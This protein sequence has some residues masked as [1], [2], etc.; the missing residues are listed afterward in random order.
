MTSLEEE[1]E[2]AY[3][4]QFSRY[5][6]NGIKADMVEDMYTKAHAA[7]RANPDHKAAAEKQVTKTLDRQEA[8][9]RGEA[10]EGQ[11][12]Q[13]RVLGSVGCPAVIF[14]PSL[15]RQSAFPSCLKKIHGP[16]QG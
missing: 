12:L 11:G 7:I 5:I 1:D 8:D 10:T 16:D 4:K 9:P 13:G 2:E 15:H 14:T 3:K 6:K